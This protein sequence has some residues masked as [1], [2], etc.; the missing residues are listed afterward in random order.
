[1][2][3]VETGLAGCF[4]VETEPIGDDRGHFARTFCARTFA[5]HGLNT[6]LAQ[7]S[8]SFNRI[9]GTLRGLHFQCHPA[10]E[11]KLVRCTA[12]AIF[13]VAVDLRLGSATFGKWFAA[14]LTAENG[15][16]LYI[17]KGFAH[18]FQT[19]SA[20]SSVAYHIAQFF[21]TERTAGVIW[22]DPE[23]GVKWPLPPMAQ[24]PRDLA[25]PS[26]SSLDRSLLM[27]AGQ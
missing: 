19:L 25:L 7:A 1:M 6:F 23:I 21:E 8:T 13:D 10:L 5:Q 27:P 16:Q 20:H 24:S 4:I 17:P 9:A 3:F 22:N 18:G 15:R 11:D 26:M 14:E 2:K 12:G